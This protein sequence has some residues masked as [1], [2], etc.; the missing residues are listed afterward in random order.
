MDSVAARAV[1]ALRAPHNWLQLAK[2]C[3][4]GASGYAINL[5]VYA[6]LLK[7]AICTTSA[8][9]SCSFL[10]AVTNNYW[11]NRHWTFRGQRATSPTRGCASRR[12]RGRARREPRRPA[13]ARRA[14]RRQGRRAGDRDR[15]RHAAELPRQQALVV[16][17]EAERHRLPGAPARP[18]RPA[19]ASR[20]ARAPPRGPRR[21]PRR[22]TT[23]KGRII[24]TPLAPPEQ[25]PR[26]DEDRATAAFLAY[27]KVARLADALPARSRA[28]SADVQRQSATGPST[29]GRAKAGEIATGKVDDLTRQG[30]RGVDGPQ[31][32]W[33]MARGYAGRV[34]RPED[35][36]LP[37][38]ARASA[39]VFLIGLVDWRR[40][41]S[42]R[43]LDLLVL[44]SFS[45]SLWYFNR[46]DIFA[47][48]P[49]VYPPLVYLI[50]RG[51]WIGSRAARRA[52]RPRLAGVDPPRGDRLRRR[53]PHRAERARIERD[54]RRLLGRDRRGADRARAGAV[55]AH[56]RSRGA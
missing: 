9:R 4:V 45:V 1:R 3:A 20:R 48:V 8:R 18:R 27:P 26:L 41:L 15:R 34:R 50:G 52:A 42:L 33:R 29:S 47:S 36:Q 46:G 13:R 6:A 24:E 55:R 38:L 21:R 10:V 49:L 2:F 40:P 17:A 12:L 14:R 35:Q 32:A 23:A 7:W 37:G 22:S 30:D 43:N 53:L 51:I 44:L 56:A 31:V 28:T 11:W 54:R 5:A 39:R 25:P 16:P 19:A